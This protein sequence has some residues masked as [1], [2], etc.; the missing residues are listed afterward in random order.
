MG[1]LDALADPMFKTDEAGQI[2]FFPA[3]KMGKGRIVPDAAA[4]AD[5]RRAVKIG[6][7][8]S[9]VL[10]VV[11]VLALDFWIALPVAILLGIAYQAF[12]LYRVRGLPKSDA[13]LTYADIS[14]AQAKAFGRGWLVALS[15]MSAVLFAS[16]IFYVF[17]VEENRWIG[18]AGVV[19][20]GTTL[21][22]FLNQ[23]RLRGR[24]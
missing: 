20:F 1:Y 17:T 11:L 10:A 4:A 14:R 6:S 7:M 3:G 21:V 15:L 2:V 22:L 9:I 13:R 24:G 23:F 12:L 18:V 19:I 8:T 5:L 16:S